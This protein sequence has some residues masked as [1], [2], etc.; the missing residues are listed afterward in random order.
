[1]ERDRHERRQREHRAIRELG[2]IADALEVVALD[3]MDGGSQKTPAWAERME[4]K[5]ADLEQAILDLQAATKSVV[6]DAKNAVVSELHRLAAEVRDAPDTDAAA[7]RISAI[8]ESLSQAAVDMQAAVD[9]SDGDAAPAEPPAEP[10]AETPAETP[11]DTGDA[12]A[13]GEQVEPLPELP[14]DAADP[15]VDTG[16]LGTEPDG[17]LPPA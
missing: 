14:G 2:R 13:D 12:P 7:E 10:P 17:D 8:A 6:E 3:V 15:A 1:M 11:A 16:D 9:E 5:M 4:A